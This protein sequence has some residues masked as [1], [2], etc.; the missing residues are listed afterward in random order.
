MLHSEIIRLERAFGQA[1]VGF[2]QRHGRTALQDLAQSGSARAMLPRTNGPVPEV[3]FLNTS[4]GLTSGDRLQFR[5]SLGDQTR[6]TA[7]T[8]TAERAYRCTG[9]AAHL[10]VSA[11]VGQGGHLDWLPQET[12]LFEDSHLI[13]DTHIALA[14]GATCLMS[15]LIVLGRRAMGERPKR[16]H[17][18][19]RRM[20]TLAGQPL[21]AETLRLDAGGLA[22]A[23]S[24][25]VLGGNVAFAVVALL[26]QGVD[27]AAV[28]LNTAAENGVETAVSAWNGRCLFRAMATDLWPLKQTLARVIA[29]L[30]GQPLP[31]VWQM[32]GVTS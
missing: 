30:S 4:G 16:A 12:I 19:D 8:Q 24:P 10:G 5:L 11:K 18:T 26:G 25:A 2:G 17:L 6:V 14:E 27:D 21:W 9:G 31:R 23:G 29:Q 1:H 15:E 7:T 3:V 22:D 28:A 13:R 32:N 20:V